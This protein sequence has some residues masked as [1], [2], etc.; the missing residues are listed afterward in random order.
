MSVRRSV[1][2]SVGPSV[3]LFFFCIYERF[4]GWIVDIQVSH[5]F[6]NMYLFNFMSFSV[7]FCHFFHDDN[8]SFFSI[9]ENLQSFTS[10]YSLLLHSLL[11]SLQSF[12]SHVLMMFQSVVSFLTIICHILCHFWSFFL[13]MTQSLCSYLFHFHEFKK[14]NFLMMTFLIIFVKFVTF[15]HFSVILALSHFF[16]F[17]VILSCSEN[18]YLVLY[19][20][21]LVI[22]RHFFHDD[23]LSFFSIFENLQSFW[24]YFSCF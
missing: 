13:L 7:I 12:T 21:F 17:F 8:L 14:K 2:R 19:L 4:K 6:Q 1:S 5:Q 24:F 23:S 11:H 22:I 9:F 20:S 10:V 15:C 16:T 18:I 3:P